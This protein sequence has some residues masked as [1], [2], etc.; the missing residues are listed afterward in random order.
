M[1]S[2][3][4]TVAVVV[5]PPTTPP[6]DSVTASG[7]LAGGFTNTMV[8]REEV[9]LATAAEIFA[10]PRAIPFTAKLAL[11]DTALTDDGTVATLV[12]L[13]PSSTV[14]GPTAPVRK[15][16][17]VVVAPS[18]TSAGDTETEETLGANSSD[19]ANKPTA[20]IECEP[21]D[22]NMIS[23]SLTRLLESEREFTVEDGADVPQFSAL[24]ETLSGAWMAG[25][26]L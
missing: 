20:R 19:A 9:V 5:F 13:L 17:P 18:L 25:F 7:E 10:Q 8:D 6:V 21:I 3:N 23:S 15:T 24:T 22:R 1:A 2:I 11:D 4:E 26:R 14:V 12:L 16:V